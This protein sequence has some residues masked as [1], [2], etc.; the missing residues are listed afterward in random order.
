MDTKNFINLPANYRNFLEEIDVFFD[1][2]NIK[3]NLNALNKIYNK[4]NEKTKNNDLQI[5][6]INRLL[7]Y[8]D[9]DNEC[10]KKLK[11][12][13]YLHNVRFLEK[14]STDKK[15]KEFIDKLSIQLKDYK[16]DKIEKALIKLWNKYIN[17][18]NA[19]WRFVEY[20]NTNIKSI[21]IIDP[22]D[23]KEILDYLTK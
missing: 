2:F 7:L 19:Y 13:V 15:Y 1:D 12:F 8:C 20:S 23:Y 11:N 22:D 18:W 10:L 21:E 17:Y 3:M 4:I 5:N 6:D 9:N 16:K 14:L